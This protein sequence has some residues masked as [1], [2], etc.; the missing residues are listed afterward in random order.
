MSN[1]YVENC[2]ALN[3]GMI[4]QDK[5][6]QIVLL[7]GSV[8]HAS[9][10]QKGSVVYSQNDEVLESD[11]LNQIGQ[12]KFPKLFGQGIQISYAL[13]IEDGGSFYI[14]SI[15]MQFE[16]LDITCSTTESIAGFGGF[17]FIKEANFIKLNN[18]QLF[19]SYSASGQQIYSQKEGLI[20][21]LSESYLY[22]IQRQALELYP[23][24]FNQEN[25]G[26]GN[27]GGGIYIKNPKGDVQII[28]SYFTRMVAFNEGGCVYYIVEEVSQ[29]DWNPF[30]NQLVIPLI[31][32]QRLEF[33]NV[34]FTTVQAYN[35][36][37][38]LVFGLQT[39]VIF[40]SCYLV[41]SYGE[42]YNS[43]F[44]KT[45]NLVEVSNFYV[46]SIYSRSKSGFL[47]LGE[48]EVYQSENDQKTKRSL[49]FY[50][51]NMG[52]S[53]YSD[54]DIMT[55]LFFKSGLQF[56]IE[57]LVMNKCQMNRLITP[58]TQALIV[59]LAEQSTFSDANSFYKDVE[60]LYGGIYSFRKAYNCT[61][62]KV[63]NNAGQVSF[64]GIL[65]F[66]N[67]EFEF[68]S[69]RTVTIR[70]STFEKILIVAGSGG[71]IYQQDDGLRSINIESVT[72]WPIYF[73]TSR[74][75]DD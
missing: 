49:L 34:R 46:E 20:F 22:Q 39:N 58:R 40:S 50:F 69:Y 12:I 48:E 55:P 70:N 45:A 15:G 59:N 4:Y 14:D 35:A 8:I 13:S 27:N 28:D 60:G 38:V 17:L 3:G 41:Q 24:L 29:Q 19:D 21:V 72:K 64:G 43:I 52:Q 66:F 30:D 36:S 47:N 33:T 26:A 56:S 51:D 9:A 7:Y 31:Q 63:T 57:S 16:L 18:L 2:L 62:Y 6:S 68:F 23:F 37:S 42:E 53:F 67:D 5:F 10:T 71:F 65:S 54:L 74:L 44:I 11:S 75:L 61:F 25:T 32:L 73:F 1:F